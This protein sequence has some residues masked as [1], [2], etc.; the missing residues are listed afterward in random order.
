M[1]WRPGPS[2]PPPP[3]GTSNDLLHIDGRHGYDDVRADF[4]VYR[5]KLSD[6]G[7]V[8]FHDTHEFQP[9]FDVHRFWGELATTAP[10]FEFHHGH[11]LGVLAVGENAPT[12]VLE[13]LAAAHSDPDG[14]RETYHRLG[15]EVGLR[16][17]A[18]V[19][20]IVSPKC[21]WNQRDSARRFGRYAP[22][23]TNGKNWPVCDGTKRHDSM[24]TLP[25]WSRRTSG[26][27][28]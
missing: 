21:R 19:S 18:P 8:I 24:S 27:A 5:G 4:E 10:S 7:V 14:V 12:V 3:A 28:G 26:S 11:G 1:Q 16:A 17:Q 6:R 25:S 15:I 23:S 2:T 22:R 9:S 20:N 13:F